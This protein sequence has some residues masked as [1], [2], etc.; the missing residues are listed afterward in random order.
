MLTAGD[1]EVDP[2]ARRVS[3]AGTPVAV[4]PREFAMLEFLMRNAGVAVSKTQILE[5]V[6]DAGFDGDPNIVEVYVNYVRRK[7][8]R[9]AIRTVRGAGYL[10]DPDGG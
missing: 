4:T 1:L 2:A 9:T 5:N 6:W 8:G 10:L 7:I 3:R